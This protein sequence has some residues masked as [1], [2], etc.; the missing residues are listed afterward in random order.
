MINS[1]TDFGSPL[2]KEEIRFWSCI[3]KV[4]M[5]LSKNGIIEYSYRYESGG[6][7]VEITNHS[8]ESM[9][10]LINLAT[11]AIIENGLMLS[12]KSSFVNSYEFQTYFRFKIRNTWTNADNLRYVRSSCFMFPFLRDRLHYDSIFDKFGFSPQMET[13]VGTFGDLKRNAVRFSKPWNTDG[14]RIL[15]KCLK[16]QQRTLKKVEL[17]I[18]DEGRKRSNLKSLNLQR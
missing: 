15:L 14:K 7:V 2:E 11:G 1:S 8:H 5:V 9:K 12:S 4:L 16:V 17:I 6:Y 18:F 3:R 13:T 10:I